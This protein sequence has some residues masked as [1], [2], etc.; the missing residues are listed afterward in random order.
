MTEIQELK[1][2]VSD[3]QI[4]RGG[5]KEQ[6]FELLMLDRQSTLGWR[7]SQH[8]FPTFLL[9]LKIQS[10]KICNH[11]RREQELLS[12][13]TIP[14]GEKTSEILTS[15]KEQHEELL[16]QQL[17]HLKEAYLQSLAS[18][19]YSNS[20]SPLHAQFDSE[21]VTLAVAPDG[22]TSSSVPMIINSEGQALVNSDGHTPVI[23]EG[24]MVTSSVLEGTDITS[25]QLVLQ[26]VRVVNPNSSDD[27]IQTDG[28]V[29]HSRGDHNNATHLQLVKAEPD[30][31][32]STDSLS[33]GN[34]FQFR[35]V[36]AVIHKD[37]SDESAPAKRQKL[38]NSWCGLPNIA[39]HVE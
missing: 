31:E 18:T 11:Q 19:Q 5:W 16:H 22:T 35:L 13:L 37:E 24:Q 32:Q 34:T 8:F 38:S 3:K 20:E 17:A 30:F 33:G 9:Q 29:I 21:V 39:F 1:M 26:S 12:Q 14:L 36:E 27:F 6:K 4:D 10:D 23:S 28:D 2:E 15:L 7:H 25:S